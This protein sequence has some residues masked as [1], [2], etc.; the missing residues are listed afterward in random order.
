MCLNIE[1][2]DQSDP[3]GRQKQIDTKGKHLKPL[4]TFFMSYHYARNF[5]LSTSE[6]NG[7][8]QFAAH[9]QGVRHSKNFVGKSG[10]CMNHSFDVIFQRM[11]RYI[12]SPK[13][14][15]AWLLHTSG[16]FHDIVLTSRR[17]CNY[18]HIDMSLLSFK[19]ACDAFKKVDS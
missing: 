16:T 1:T 7:G 4:H 11:I 6:L 14:S 15:E 3:C 10:L 18:K 13:S 12:H 8:S 19:M 17:C 5:L 9:W 2:F